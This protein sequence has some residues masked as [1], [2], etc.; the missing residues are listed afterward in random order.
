MLKFDINSKGN[1]R[2]TTSGITSKVGQSV[3]VCWVDAH[4]REG[5]YLVN[6]TETLQNLIDNRQVL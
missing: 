3:H 5:S 4:L 6:F 2:L 1:I